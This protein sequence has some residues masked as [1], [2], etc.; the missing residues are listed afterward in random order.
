MV[1]LIMIAGFGLI[2]GVIAKLL[3]PGRD[4]GGIIMTAILGIAG[5]LVGTFIA[6]NV[7]GVHWLAR[8]PWIAAILGSVLL[9]AAYRVVAGRQD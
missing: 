1:D 6:R 2:V 9:L 4:P 5:S 8:S 3:M 7:L